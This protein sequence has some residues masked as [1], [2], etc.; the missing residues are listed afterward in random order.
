MSFGAIKK[1][2][3]SYIPYS[4]YRDD[5]PLKL[6][7]EYDHKDKERRKNYYK[8]HGEA[9]PDYWTPKLLS[10]IYLWPK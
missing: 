10:G 3:N 6:Y 8:R 5:T 7:T 9:D 4:Q 2:N 1:E